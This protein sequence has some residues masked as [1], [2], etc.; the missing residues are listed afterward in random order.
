MDRNGSA[1][2]TPQKARL[3]MV[4]A[5]RNTYYGAARLR[6]TFS[7]IKAHRKIPALLP[8][9]L[10]LPN[11]L[12]FYCPIYCPIYCLLHC[13]LYQLIACALLVNSLANLVANSVAKLNG[14]LLTDQ[15]LT[16]QL[17][18]QFTAYNPLRIFCQN[19]PS[20]IHLRLYPAR[21]ITCLAIA[22]IFRHMSAKPS[23]VTHLSI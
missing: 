18:T 4:N 23:I 3:P 22:D 7:I 2:F 16:D 10:Q 14:Q 12:A 13:P 8:N 15:L 20:L 21:A 1:R 9:A 19:G 11:S 5:Y 17:T 6:V